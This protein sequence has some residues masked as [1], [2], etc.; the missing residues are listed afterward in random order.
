MCTM[1]EP[2]MVLNLTLH[3]QD[4]NVKNLLVE[5]TKDELD[6]LIGSL[7]KAQKVGIMYSNL[8]LRLLEYNCT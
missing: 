7:E 6:H 2:K 3:Q 4:G 5:M 8:F 1:K